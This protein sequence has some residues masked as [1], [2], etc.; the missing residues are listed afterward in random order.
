MIQRYTDLIE[1]K[2]LRGLTAEEEAEFQKIIQILD[3]EEEAH[4]KPIK[5]R[6]KSQ[7][8]RGQTNNWN[9]EQQKP[10][11]YRQVLLDLDDGDYTTGHWASK[12]GHWI[13][14]AFNQSPPTYRLAD[15]AVIR[16]RYI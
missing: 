1:I 13:G 6:L 9:T 12:A 2:L 7:L 8:K 4:F 3:A 15:G 14:Y 16:W 11:P 10:E 5:Q